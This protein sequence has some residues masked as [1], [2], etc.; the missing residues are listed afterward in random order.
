M[1]KNIP[2]ILFFLSLMF[3][4]FGYGFL[5]GVGK[6]FPYHQLR[7]AIVAIGDEL[8]PWFYVKA[9]TSRVQTVN[10]PSRT[11]KGLNLV[12][13]VGPDKTLTAKIVD[14]DGKELHRWDVDWFSIWPDADHVGNRKPKTRPGTTIDGAVL[15]PE[16]DLIFNY[17]YLGLVRLAKDGHVVWRLPYQTHHTIYTDD[18]GNLWVPGMI[19]RTEPLPGFPNY[20]ADFVE[21]TA[22]KVSTE[23]KILREIK[24]FDVLKDNGLYGLLTMATTKQ[25]DTTVSGDTLHL[26]DVEVFPR[27]MKEG[28]FRHGDVMISLRNPNAILVL[29]PDGKVKYASIG[30]YVRQHDPDFVDGNSFSVFDNNNITGAAHPSSR[31]VLEHAPSGKT[32]T[33]YEGTDATPFFTDIMGKHQWL[34]NGNLLITETRGGR[35]FE[36]APG[37]E[38]VWDYHNVA[39]ENI[40]GALDGVQRLPAQFN[41]IFGR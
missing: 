14:M 17:E 11:M 16:G 38:I 1:K 6:L 29:T 8:H 4:S 40:L 32:E 26:N 13:G 5:A 33:I 20:R 21:Y 24:L 19:D 34:P 9:D 22:I 37:G 15:T 7:D 25:M 3:F 27:H 35:A 10:D 2:L 41:T 36:V 12:T 30:K 39:G 18:D 23:G 28:F 31:I